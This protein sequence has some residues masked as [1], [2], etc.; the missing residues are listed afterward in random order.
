MK[1]PATK[2]AAHESTQILHMCSV[3]DLHIKVH[4]CSTYVTP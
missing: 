3:H 4:M 1:V 2:S